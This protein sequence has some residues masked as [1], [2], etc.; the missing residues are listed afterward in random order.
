MLRSIMTLRIIII[1]IM[2]LDTKCCSADQ[3]N[4]I[5]NND[6]QHNVIDNKC[7]YAEGHNDP[8]NNHY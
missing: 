2:L 6:S 3:H 5:Q 7:C 8:Q 4:D 1:S